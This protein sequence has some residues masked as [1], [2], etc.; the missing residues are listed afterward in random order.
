MS[1]RE[2]LKACVVGVAGKN[3]DFCMFHYDPG[4]S[5]PYPLVY[6]SGGDDCLRNVTVRELTD[7]EKEYVE[8]A[9]TL[10]D[11]GR[12]YVKLSLEKRD[13]YGSLSGFCAR[14]SY[15]EM[16]NVQKSKS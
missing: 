12:P 5:K 15:G 1:D 8:T 3:F 16:E 14:P 7:K 10:D 6:V 4:T 11:G 2:P 13:G 9:F